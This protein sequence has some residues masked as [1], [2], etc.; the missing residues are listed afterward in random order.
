[1]TAV[2]QGVSCIF[3]A[4]PRVHDRPCRA[5]EINLTAI[6]RRLGLVDRQP[7]AIIRRVRL[8]AADYG[9]PLPKTPRFINGVRITGADS[10]DARS[11]WDR[12]AVDLWFEDD[13][14]PME[15]AA[16]VHARQAAVRDSMRERALQLV[17]A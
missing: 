14:P 8:L 12:D 16:A 5:N 6:A 13:R 11:I 10:I 1:M 17:A 3:T 9:F 7:R 4:P 15:A 2:L